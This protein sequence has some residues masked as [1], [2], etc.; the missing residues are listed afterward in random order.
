MFLPLSR[1][2]W[3]GPVTDSSL[4]MSPLDMTLGGF[5]AKYGMTWSSVN[6][7]SLTESPS[8]L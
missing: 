5:C 6:S 7:N 2:A 1:I 8:A 4:G 3:R